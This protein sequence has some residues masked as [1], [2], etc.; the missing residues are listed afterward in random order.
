MASNLREEGDT[1]PECEQKINQLC[2]ILVIII[3]KNSV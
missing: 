3:V 1:S 2:R